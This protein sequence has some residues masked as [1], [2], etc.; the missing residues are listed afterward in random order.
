MNR[1]HAFGDD[2]LGDHDAV[3]LVEKLRA[4]EVSRARAR[5]GGDRPH[6]GGQPGTERSGIR[7]VRPRAGQGERATTVWRLL[8]RGADRSS[9]TTSPSRACRRCR[10]PMHGSR[11]RC[12]ADGEFARV[13]LSTGLIPLGK[14]QM[15]EFGF[16]GSAEHPRIGPVRNPW[17]PEY[18]AGASSSGSAAFVAAGVVPIAHANDGGGSIRIPAACNG[19]VGLKPTRGRLPLDKRDRPD[20]AAPRRQRGGDRGRCATPRR[21]CARPSGPTATRSSARSATSPIRAS[22]GCGSH[23]APN[24]LC[25]KPARRSAS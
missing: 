3:G 4:G 9:R 1:I 10:A 23:S 13:F 24:P 6:R 15:S 7:G 19:L 21:S 5:R 20:A 25:E 11:G 18:T 17:N 14:T 22:S 2:A 16:S 12:R 8:R